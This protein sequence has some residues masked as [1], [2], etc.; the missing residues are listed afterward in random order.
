M[1]T[2]F[3]VNNSAIDFP[4]RCAQE[5]VPFWNGTV[6]ATYSNSNLPQ[7]TQLFQV[8]TLAGQAAYLQSMV[9]QTTCTTEMLLWVRNVENNLTP[10]G[11]Y[12]GLDSGDSFSIGSPFFISDSKPALIDF[13]GMWIRE[14]TEMKVA[15]LLSAGYTGITG[16][17]R[18]GVIG[19]RFTNDLNFTAQKTVLMIGD[20]ICKGSLG[21]RNSFNGSDIY[22]WKVRDYFKSKG[23]DTRLV[24]KGAG[25]RTS[26]DG[27]AWMLQQFYDIL[28]ADLILWNFG[29]NDVTGGF[30]AGK[31]QTYSD[32]IDA[33][34]AWK[35]GKYPNAI[36]LMLGPTPA[37]ENT[38]EAA[39]EIAR[40]IVEQRVANAADEKV[41]Y[42]NLG[43][44]FD[45]SVNA[46]FSSTDSAGDRLHPSI[47]G[48]QQIYDNK[49][50][51]FFETF[52]NRI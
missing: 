44:A 39:L 21:V 25:G 7:S 23:Q 28:N 5:A 33:A 18:L 3:P 47:L 20:S 14:N 34:I 50:V 36:L 31:Q 27:R 6:S 32:N 8:Y 22:P 46:N 11:G 40:T 4:T 51:P 37:Q 38:R 49:F 42:L 43:D 30:G 41:M 48:H 24:N 2:Q 15:V 29:M 45:R 9:V 1:A 35:Q 13:G 12:E 26:T 16:D 19:Y 52:L 17:F 10:N